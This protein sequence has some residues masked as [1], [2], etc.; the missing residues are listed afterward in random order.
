MSRM[1]ILGLA[2]AYRL[3]MPELKKVIQLLI[4]V[5]VQVMMFLLQD[6]LLE[7]KAK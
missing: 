7:K 3:S 4:L 5:L 1:L 2:A 6:P